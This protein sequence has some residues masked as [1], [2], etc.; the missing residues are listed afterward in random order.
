MSLL[1]TLPTEAGRETRTVAAPSHEA[2]LLIPLIVK[3]VAVEL[4]PRVVPIEHQHAQVT[5]GVALSYQTPSISSSSK[6]FEPIVRV[7]AVVHSHC[8]WHLQYA[9]FVWHQVSSF[10]YE[11]LSAYH[12]PAS[13]NRPDSGHS[14][15]LV[16]AAGIR[17]RQQIHLLP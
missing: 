6:A 15:D 11:V 5:I 1:K 13:R 12:T 2:T 16:S 8:F 7:E 4:S 14:G 17:E 9:L 3:P 10:F